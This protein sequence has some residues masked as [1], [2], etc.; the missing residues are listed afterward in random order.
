[1]YRYTYQRAVFESER[2]SAHDRHEKPSQQAQSKRLESPTYLNENYSTLPLQRAYLC[3]KSPPLHAGNCYFL[4]KD[5]LR[6]HMTD[7]C[8]SVSCGLGVGDLAVQDIALSQAYLQYGGGEQDARVGTQWH[9]LARD[10][11][12]RRQGEQ[13]HSR[14]HTGPGEHQ[15]SSTE[16]LLTPNYPAAVI[17]S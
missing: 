5:Q 9:A 14:A 12:S 1:M 7:T 6:T 3:A 17:S 10:R 16:P 2:G 8:S 11:R 13:T 15:S 4:T